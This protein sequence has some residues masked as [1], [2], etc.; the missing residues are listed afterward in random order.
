Q[1]VLCDWAN[2]AFPKF[3]P[4][5][6]T[7]QQPAFDRLDAVREPGDRRQTG[8]RELVVPASVER[9]E[10]PRWDA[11]AVARFIRAEVDAGRRRW[12][13]FLV[14]AF[15]KAALASYASALE[16]LEIPVEVSGAASF[17]ASGS[18]AV[19][20]TLL[21]ALGDP[22]DE[23]ALVG[24]LRGP[25][26]GLS[27]VELF[28]HVQAGARPPARDAAAG[29]CRGTRRRRPPPAPR[30]V[31]SHAPPACPCRRRAHPRGLRLAR[32]RRRRQPGR[33]RGR[34][35]APRSGPRPADH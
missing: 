29:D 12:G 25:L 34:A 2:E 26:F 9:G 6:P 21:G 3:F 8:V 15:R 28:R 27:D 31:A 32:R 30:V 20:A 35:P 11:E 7:P 14:L 22:A 10:V 23:P 5:R 1:P 19:L 13:G 24:V 17:T 33:R 4:R 16:A 18:V